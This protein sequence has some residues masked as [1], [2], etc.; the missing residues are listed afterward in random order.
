MRTSSI[1]GATFLLLG[2]GATAVSAAVDTT[3]S[4][5]TLNGSDTLFEVTQNIL[6]A[7]P[8]AVADGI[9]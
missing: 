3:G 7:C 5:L 9:S 2:A 4:N 8:T 1:A 6:T